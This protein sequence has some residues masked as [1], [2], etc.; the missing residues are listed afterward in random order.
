MGQVY[1]KCEV[2]NQRNEVVLFC[3]H[4]YLVQMKAAA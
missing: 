1:E 3:E 2:I 4:I